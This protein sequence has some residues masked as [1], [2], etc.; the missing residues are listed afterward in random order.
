V[1]PV[2]LAVEPSPSPMQGK[3]SGK[4]KG[5]AAGN[6]FAALMRAA[7]ATGEK[8]GQTRA[9][10]G[11]KLAQTETAA[12]LIT[13]AKANIARGK[14]DDA[15]EPARVKDDPDAP[16]ADEVEAKAEEIDPLAM[17]M[18]AVTAPQPQ[19]T[20]T[21]TAPA[22]ATGETVEPEA[23]VDAEA[24]LDTGVS[25]RPIAGLASLL[26]ERKAQ[27]DTPASAVDTA[28]AKAT[29]TADAKAPAAP[30]PSAPGA[31]NKSDAA[32]F[33]TG[34]NASDEP[35]PAKRDGA[36]LASS[37]GLDQKVT[38]VSTQVAPA[39]AAPVAAPSPTGAA[40]VVS[41]DTDGTLKS[42]AT[43]TASA[44]PAGD[45]KP[46]TTLKLQLHPAELGNVT[47]QISGSGDEIAIE[48]QVEN[49]E[50]RHRLSSDSD[51]IV[52][53]LRGL[54]YE[55]ERITVQ[56]IAP[57]ANAGQQQGATGGGRGDGFQSFDQHSGERGQSQQNQPNSNG[58]D[59]GEQRT[60]SS[61]AADRGSAAG[62]VYI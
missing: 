40:L 30:E 57:S 26:A 31:G 27:G 39:P 11:D 24:E 38:I 50:A 20:A 62:A 28:S 17:L 61:S 45:A 16:P 36:S 44:L 29:A 55:V 53:S 13:A 25:T 33:D 37:G 8:A 56:Q 58:R 22:S 35:S 2:S 15:V 34:W 4:G 21:E 19:A 47:V 9:E 12:T 51:A 43:E 60:A 14:D 1:S 52:K 7:A 10:R 41:L 46:V 23:E 42:Y 6:A 18:S 54:G 3:P 49:S 59:H 5:A 48:V 32:A